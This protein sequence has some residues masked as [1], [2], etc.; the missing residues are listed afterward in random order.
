MFIKEGQIFS[1]A[2][3]QKNDSQNLLNFDPKRSAKGPFKIPIFDNI[4]VLRT[5]IHACKKSANPF[6]Q[7]SG[8]FLLIKLIRLQDAKCQKIL[9]SY[10]YHSD[11]LNFV[12]FFDIVLY[13]SEIGKII[14]NNQ[15]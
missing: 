5:V 1:F 14:N 13:Y 7:V 15:P 4:T 11:N 8:C 10:D 6:I 9:R 12:I 3:V 2:L